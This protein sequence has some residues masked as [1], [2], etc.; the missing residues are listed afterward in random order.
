MLLLYHFLRYTKDMKITR[1]EKLFGLTLLIIFGGIVLHAPISVGFGTL[2]PKYALLIKSWKEI[3]LIIATVMAIVI[4]SKRHLWKE[5]S[6]DTLLRLIALYGALHLALL[7]V[8]YLGVNETAAGLAIDL[9]YLLF[10]TLVYVL[11]KIAPGYRWYIGWTCAIGA[12]V[13]V[14]FAVLQL[15]LPTDS[16]KYIGYNSHTIAPYMTVDDNADYVRLNSTLRGPNP[17]GAYAVIVLTIAVAF[18]LSKIKQLNTPRIRYFV[19]WLAFASIVALWVSYSRS[20]LVAGIGAATFVMVTKLAPRVSR[21]GWILSCV[22]LFAIL[23]GLVVARDSAVVSTIILHDDPATGS[24]VS[25]NDNHITSLS[26]GVAR[27]IA[28]PL[29]AGI[30]ST[31]SA[32]LFGDDGLII[33]NQYLFVA[34]ESGWLGLGIFVA[35][36]GLILQRLWQRKHDYMALGL[37]ASGIGLA[38]VGLLLPVWVDDTVS[39]IWFGLAAVAIIGKEVYGHAKTNKKTTRTA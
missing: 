23:G 33:E 7:T 27:V 35:I 9:R 13:V 20:A 14:T 17:L 29:G 28:Q 38:F 34:H 30:G 24:K 2:F 15:F 25:S 26:Q 11:V 3:L 31:G 16:L 32:S 19:Y 37:F 4:V 8:T 6:K 10:F 18:S 39:L 1:L 22:V 5:F 21:R 12:F 36:F